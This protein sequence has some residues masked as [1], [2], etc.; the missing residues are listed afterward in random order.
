[1]CLEAESCG[2]PASACLRALPLD[3]PAEG[4]LRPVTTSPW[5]I[6]GKAGLSLGDVRVWGDSVASLLARGGD[7]PSIAGRSLGPAC[8][9]MVEPCEALCVSPK[10]GTWSN[11]GPSGEAFQLQLAPG[12]QEEKHFGS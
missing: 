9:E 4:G 2:D 12:P 5:Y 6:R 3:S 8:A 10:A 1:M 7:Q 11:G